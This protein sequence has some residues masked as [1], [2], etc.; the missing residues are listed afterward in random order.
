M[1]DKF[2][3]VKLANG[4]TV[5]LGDTVE[6]INSDRHVCRDKIKIHNGRLYFWNNS[7]SPADYPNAKKVL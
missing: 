6:F 7:F 5:K 3:R 4:E 2:K 1:F